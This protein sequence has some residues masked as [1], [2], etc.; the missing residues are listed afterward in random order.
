MPIYLTGVGTVIAYN[1]DVVRQIQ[2]QIISINFT[3]GQTDHMRATCWRK[4][5]PRPCRALI[6]QYTAISSATRH[7]SSMLRPILPL[8]HVGRQGWRP[9]RSCS[10][11]RKAQVGAAG[12]GVRADR[13]LI[14]SAKVELSYTRP[15][16]PIDGD[17]RDSIR[18][19]S[20]TSSVRQLRT[21]SSSSHS[22]IDFALIFTASDGL[23]ADPAAT[24]KTQDRARGAP[25]IRM[26]A[27]RS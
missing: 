7:S 18:S 8:H 17:G 26:M 13:A 20:A 25:T 14:D 2:G 27:L 10:K 5:D 12:G 21:A 15:A 23:S 22:S 1:T 6:D 11:P 16:S 24:A 19:T 9:L 3:E 4:I